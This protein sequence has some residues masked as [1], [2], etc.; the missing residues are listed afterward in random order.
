MCA[1]K[2]LLEITVE[3]RCL[4]PVYPLLWQSEKLLIIQETQAITSGLHKAVCSPLS[5]VS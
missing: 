4:S 5:G 3:R 2:E 1:C